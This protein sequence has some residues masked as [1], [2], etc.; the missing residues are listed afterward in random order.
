MHS[1]T[2]RA[3]TVALVGL[4]PLVAGA[5]ADDTAALR[6]QL[7]ALIERVER[8]EQ[9]LAE[10]ESTNERQTDQLAQASVAA[11]AASWAEKIRFAGD[12]RYRHELID[13]DGRQ[14]R[15]RQR[16]RARFGLTAQVG[17]SLTA[18]LRIATGGVSENRSTNATLGDA[19]ARKDLELDLG[20]LTWKPRDDLSLT[21]GKQV[22][23][24]F[25]PGS[26]FLYDSDSN[27]EG[28]ALAWSGSSGAF[29]NA[30]GFWLSESGSAAEGNVSGLQ[31]GWRGRSGL[32]VAA[33][34]H[35]YAALQGRSLAFSGYPA[36]NS[37]YAG[38]RLCVPVATDVAV[39]RCYS[40]D[41]EI[42]GLAVQYEASVGEWPLQLW[43]DS[44]Q[45]LAVERLDSGFN[46]GARLGRASSPGSWEL[47]LVYQ[48]VEADAQWGGF[49]DSDFAG[50]D[51]QGRGWR[52]QG[53]WVPTRN[54]LLQF[55]WIDST[56]AVDLP[57]Q[58]DYQRLQLDFSM[59][60]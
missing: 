26:S 9:Q 35:D 32:T 38:D 56:R 60:F 10:A 11:R 49:I 46:L 59:K 51:T 33:S 19:N 29:A 15:Q 13:E 54:A 22:Y 27:P 8:L 24:W 55:T 23:P 48:D 45:N 5:A 47:A 39:A 34:F 1:L 40:D 21:L 17:E 42:L 52:L 25:R 30:W 16:I 41:Y 58:R 44:V 7:A 37:T 4:C 28:M 20:Y 18:G 6:S 43:A 12:F 57:A 2:L 36:G 3:V 53:G 31:V 50:G 14:E